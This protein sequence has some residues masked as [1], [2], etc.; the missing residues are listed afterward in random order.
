MPN[1]QAVRIPGD[2]NRSVILELY[3]L[4]SSIYPRDCESSVVG[5]V[6]EDR[7]NEIKIRPH[8]WIIRVFSLVSTIFVKTINRLNQVGSG[9]ID[10]KRMEAGQS[11][12]PGLRIRGIN[13]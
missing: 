10:G 13:R 7:F 4:R 9:E 11:Q 2:K 8:Q 1:K 5:A 6:C 3:A 12:C